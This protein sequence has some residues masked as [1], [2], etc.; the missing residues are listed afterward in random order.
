MATDFKATDFKSANFYPLAAFHPLAARVLLSLVYLINGVAMLGAF[1]NI[2]ALMANKGIPAPDALLALTIGFWLVGGSCLVA[3]WWTRLAACVL[4]LVTIP[5]TLVF[6]AP[7]LA[8]PA[9]LHNELNHFLKNLAIL[10]GLLYVVAFGSGPYS[11][12]NRKTLAS[13]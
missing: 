6:H 9:Q 13:L 12:D 3:G 7:W 2:S 1:S 11:V 4:L 5:V 8:D 10:G